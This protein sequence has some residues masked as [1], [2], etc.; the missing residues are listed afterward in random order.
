MH[1]SVGAFGADVDDI[2]FFQVL[3][4]ETRNILVKTFKDSIAM[5]MLYKLTVQAMERWCPNLSGVVESSVDS[6]FHG[7]PTIVDLLS[8]TGAATDPRLSIHI[9]TVGQSDVDGCF[10]L[11]DAKQL[12]PDMALDN[13]EVPT[14]CLMDE[15]GRQGFLSEARRLVHSVDSPLVFDNRNAPGKA[16][17]FRCLLSLGDLLARGVVS[18]SSDMHQPYYTLLLRNPAAAILGLSAAKYKELLA[19]ETGAPAVLPALQIAAVPPVPPA[20]ED[21]VVVNPNIVGDEPDPDD[22]PLLALVD[23]AAS[24]TNSSGSS[25]SSSDTSVSA[26][27]DVGI[28]GE[29]EDSDDVQELP[30]EILGQHVTVETHWGEAGVVKSRG[31]RVKCLNPAHDGHTKYRQLGMDA[32]IFGPRSAEF[33]LWA[34]LAKSHELAH[35]DHKKCRPTRAEVR[36]IADTYG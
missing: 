6:F 3:E 30:N 11:S 8:L 7:D 28:V 5:P 2:R 14:L 33:Y 23:G 25:S 13:P 18:F 12:H 4:L 19:I 31:L 1:I 22:V 36:Q 35:D 26:H 10:E 32:A 24:S 27:A 15:L 29:E 21:G 16:N 20:I 17:Y 34:W 9:W